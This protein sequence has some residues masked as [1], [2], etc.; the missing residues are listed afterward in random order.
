MAAKL[1]D[2]E[3]EG[4]YSKKVTS[5]AAGD[6]HSVMLLT[7][8]TVYTCGRGIEGQLGYEDVTFMLMPG[9]IHALNHA[10]LPIT[11]VAAGR[12]HTLMLD[13]DGRVWSC[14][15]S[16]R[17]Q[18]GIG[19]GAP[20]TVLPQ[21]VLEG[22]GIAQIVAG[23][24]YS[25]ARAATGA[26]WVWGRGDWGQL[27]LGDT[28]DRGVPT[29]VDVLE[30]FKVKDI[31][32]GEK[33][34][35]VVISQE[36]CLLPPSVAAAQAAA[37][38]AAAAESGMMRSKRSS[39]GDYDSL[40]REESDHDP[41]WR[42]RGRRRSSVA[43]S[44]FGSDAHVSSGNSRQRRSSISQNADADAISFRPRRASISQTVDSGF[45]HNQAS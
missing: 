25:I 27:G 2:G 9:K 31:S 22:K 7:D 28:E 26:V 35:V 20:I 4:L 12:A 29:K 15:S 33:H 21:V 38:Q 30:G 13:R 6:W 40:W 42:S 14:G 18:C 1:V 3:E 41:S 24:E 11:Q 44:L 34:M 17:G 8:G 32:G 23:P 45:G 16:E 37:A 36:H 39:G 43:G 19:V 10:H 5:L